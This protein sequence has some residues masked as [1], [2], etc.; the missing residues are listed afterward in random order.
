M[1]F[2]GCFCHPT[3]FAKVEPFPVNPYS[4]ETTNGTCNNSN[5]AAAVSTS[6]STAGI[7]ASSRPPSHYIARLRSPN[8]Q[9]L[10]PAL[11]SSDASLVSKAGCGGSGTNGDFGVDGTRPTS[12]C[13][14]STATL[15]G[16]AASSKVCVSD[17]G[18]C[19]GAGNANSNGN[20]KA[21]DFDER[22]QR[23]YG[24][25]IMETG[26]KEPGECCDLASDGGDP[27]YRGFLYDDR[28]GIAWWTKIRGV[29]IDTGRSVAHRSRRQARAGGAE[30]GAG[31]G[32][33]RGGGSS[34]GGVTAV[35]GEEGEEEEAEEKE[36][37]GAPPKRSLDIQGS[38]GLT[39][40]GPGPRSRSRSP[41][42]S[43]RSQGTSGDDDNATVEQPETTTPMEVVGRG[44]GFGDTKPDDEAADA[45]LDAFTATVTFES[46]TPAAAAAA[47]LTDISS[48]PCSPCL[49][50]GSVD[51]TGAATTAIATVGGSGSTSPNTCPTS[52]VP[53][54][55]P[56]SPSKA[57]T[58]QS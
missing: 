7:N 42:S 16:I 4:S 28:D 8:G 21:Q 39:T 13:A 31:G 10:K 41:C 44:S 34:S 55:P 26:I 30:D 50:Y 57:R 49:T 14:L 47:D 33:V 17:N 25:A 3:S 11:K 46:S 22:V 36:D 35:D 52:G 15:S 40:W 27:P 6:A 20:G 2:G 23:E 38:P 43:S 51:S 48:A 32:G 5:A 19:R 53:T 1:V 58:R 37:L 45:P 54:L 29:L 12:K 9:P 56:L 24:S 18:A